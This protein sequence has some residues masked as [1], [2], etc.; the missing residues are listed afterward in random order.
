MVGRL[1]SSM[2]NLWTFSCTYWYPIIGSINQFAAL[3]WVMPLG[4]ISV[5]CTGATKEENAPVVDLAALIK[6]GFKD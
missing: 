3:H 5:P 1:P 2:P 4:D 6:Q